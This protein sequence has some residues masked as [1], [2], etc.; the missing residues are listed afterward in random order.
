MLWHHGTGLLPNHLP[1]KSRRAR[2]KTDEDEARW[3]SAENKY[4]GSDDG[5]CVGDGPQ[6]GAHH[7]DA[8]Q[9]HK[10]AAIHWALPLQDRLNAG[11]G[12][13]LASLPPADCH[14]I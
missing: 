14:N 13:S 3:T 1:S 9:A 5:L 10:M 11:R 7:P 12:Y 4:F 6:K 8:C 2:E